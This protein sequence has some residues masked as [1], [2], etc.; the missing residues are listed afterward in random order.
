MKKRSIR[1]DFLKLVLAGG[2]IITDRFREVCKDRLSIPV[3]EYYG[4]IEIGNLGYETPEHDGLHLNED[5][6]YYEF[7]NKDGMPLE[8]GEIGDLVVTRLYDRAMPLIRYNVGDRVIFKYVKSEN[9]ETI[10]KISSINGRDNQTVTLPDGTL[11]EEFH[12]GR[13]IYHYEELQ[14]FRIIQEQP[15]FFRILLVGEYN[16]CAR[17]KSTIKEG[18]DKMLRP[19]S[20]FVIERVPEIPIDNSGKFRTLITYNEYKRE[21]DNTVNQ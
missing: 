2:E 12:F 19:M 10:R 16:Y 18:L 9:G 17:I 3:T 15:D 5:L 1:I 6:I 20:S 7:L 4:M 14:Q 11:L 21:T 8:E 13:F